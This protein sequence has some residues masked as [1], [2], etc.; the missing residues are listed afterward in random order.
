MQPLPITDPKLAD[1]IQRAIVDLEKYYPDHIVSGLE[2]QHKG[3]ANRLGEAAKQ[4]GYPSRAELM[5]AYGFQ[6]A[7]RASAGAQGGRPV[8]TDAGA[9]FA[10]LRSRYQSKALPKTLGELT[11]QNPDLGGKLKTLNNKSRELF[12]STFKEV[13]IEEGLLDATPK[14]KSSRVSKEQIE[15][16]VGDLLEIYASSTGKPKTVKALQRENPEYADELDALIAH[17]KQWFGMTARKYLNDAGV[18]AA[19]EVCADASAA[20]SVLDELERMFAS[21]PDS[22]KPQSV[23]ALLKLVP[24]YEPQIASLRKSWNATSGT[25]FVETLRQRGILRRSD[26]EKRRARKETVKR[27]V[28]NA[29][30]EELVGVWKQAGGPA[31][32]SSGCASSL[33]PEH[34]RGIDVDALVELRETTLC[35]T[36]RRFADLRAGLSLSY[37]AQG[38]R[39]LFKDASSEMRFAVDYPKSNENRVYQEIVECSGAKSSATA[40]SDFVSAEIVSVSDLPSK[41]GASS[42]S[43]IPDRLG[44]PTDSDVSNGACFVQARLRYLHSLTTLTML[45]LLVRAGLITDDDLLGSDAWRSRDYV[46]VGVPASYA[47][48]AANCSNAL[49]GDASTGDI[50]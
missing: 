39:I 25:T 16:M 6:T 35:I 9:V 11:E 26:S 4:A 45:N 23:A 27:F 32:L 38:F 20:A 49:T 44:V 22:E 3:L 43:G 40:L 46:A 7:S 18:L 15:A 13:L 2:K 31:V 14:S 47:E 30:L 19:S 29:S 12:G 37:S 1:K 36:P 21:R 8:S 34:V 10:E 42:E 17:A 50:R 48:L 33:L 41:S 5:E 24:M 28:R